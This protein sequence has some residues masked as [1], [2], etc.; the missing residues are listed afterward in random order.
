M[1][2][3]RHFWGHACPACHYAQDLPNVVGLPAELD[4]WQRIWTEKKEKAE[5][6]PEKIGSTLKIVDPASFPNVFTILQILAKILVT[7]CSCTSSISCLRY[8]KTYRRGTMGEE[9]LN[10]LAI[11]HAHRDIPLNLDKIID[12]FASLHPR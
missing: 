12:L 6:T 2:S 7:S 3:S 4:L 9:S 8:L 1:R 10:G 5:D 11:M